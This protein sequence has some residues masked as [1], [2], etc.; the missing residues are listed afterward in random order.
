MLLCPKHLYQGSIFLSLQP[1]R[2]FHVLTKNPF[3]FS[4]DFSRKSNRGH[5]VTTN[6]TTILYAIHKFIIEMLKFPHENLLR[7]SLT[8]LWTKEF[9]PWVFGSIKM[10]KTPSFCLSF[11]CI[12]PLETNPRLWDLLH[13]GPFVL[14]VQSD[15]RLN[16]Q[17]FGVAHYK[18]TTRTIRTAK[19]V[20]FRNISLKVFR[21]VS[22]RTTLRLAWW[23][24]QENTLQQIRSSTGS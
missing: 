6:R 18:N 5:D 8:W 3:I 10:T 14:C 15:E 2:F 17:P 4:F 20:R 9:A 11:N 13:E 23:N 22:S 19:F 16:T 7:L 21:S 1:V 24:L 12:F